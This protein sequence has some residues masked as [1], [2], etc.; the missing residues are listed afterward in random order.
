[1]YLGSGFGVS[2]DM[3][4]TN[5]GFGNTGFGSIGGGF[6]SGNRADNSNQYSFK[7]II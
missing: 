3:S 4:T 7:S 6:G 5:T 2:N 1:L